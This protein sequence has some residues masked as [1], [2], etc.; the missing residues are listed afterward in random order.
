VGRYDYERGHFAG[1]EQGTRGMASF[2]G[3]MT[4]FAPLWS[5]LK[6]T[7]GNVGL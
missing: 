7:S 5:S 1:R 2:A 6:C 4:D 3:L